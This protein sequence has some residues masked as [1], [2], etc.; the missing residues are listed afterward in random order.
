M[1]ATE[2][3]MAHRNNMERYTGQGIPW[4]TAGEMCRLES[5]AHSSEIRDDPDEARRL[6][7]EALHVSERDNRCGTV[8][9]DG[10]CTTCGGTG[11]YS[12]GIDCGDCDAAAKNRAMAEVPR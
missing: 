2:D 10:V 12:I 11:L 4:G 5:V 3:S 9:P 8:D 1:N 7:L 6:R